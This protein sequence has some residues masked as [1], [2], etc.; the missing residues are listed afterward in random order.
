MSKRP[1]GGQVQNMVKS[2]H[3]ILQSQPSAFNSLSPHLGLVLRQ[4]NTTS[5]L[6]FD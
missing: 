4:F 5:N 2:D 6:V 3:Q 1:S